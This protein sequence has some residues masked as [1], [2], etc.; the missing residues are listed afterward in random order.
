M[1]KFVLY[2]L[3]DLFTNILGSV[4]YIFSSYLDNNHEEASG[5]LPDARH[6]TEGEDGEATPYSEQHS[7]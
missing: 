2:S 6:Y 5:D 4:E 3:I 1:L 7:H